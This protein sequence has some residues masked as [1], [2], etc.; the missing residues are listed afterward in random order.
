MSTERKGYVVICSECSETEMMPVHA[1]VR[2]IM[3]S[4]GDN[5]KAWWARMSG[6]TATLED[7]G[8]VNAVRAVRQFLASLSRSRQRATELR[9]LDQGTTG[10][11]LVESGNARISDSV[12]LLC[13]CPEDCV[14]IDTWAHLDEHGVEALWDEIKILR[15][16]NA[17]LRRGGAASIAVHTQNKALRAEIAA[18]RRGGGAAAAAM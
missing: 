12:T 9:V 6:G 11:E 14:E 3:E 15:A 18:L 2:R 13:A 8:N 16:K 10:Y 5:F 17:R 7:R 1:Y 4:E